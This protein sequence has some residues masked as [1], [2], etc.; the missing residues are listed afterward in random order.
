MSAASSSD[1][2]VLSVRALN[3]A[4]LDR[5]HLLR[6][7]TMSVPDLLESLVGMQAQTPHTAYVGLWT[8]LQGFRP[9]DL[10][11]RL[12]DRSVVRVALQR[13]TIH[14]VTA[15]D[16]WGLRPLVQPVLDRAQKGQFGKRLQGVDM[17]EVTA[18]G[19]AF[20]DTEPRTFKALGDHLLTR[21][22][23]RDRAALE[24]ASGPA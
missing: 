16:A 23:D 21:W 10:S 1:V 9:D 24:R 11:E 5:Q 3:R 17:A 15:S 22:P 2:P 19:R 14:L 6:R 20:V 4:T 12:L 18:M 13:G 8:C 7:T